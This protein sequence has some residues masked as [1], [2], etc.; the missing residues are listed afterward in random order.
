ERMLDQ[1]DQ[2]AAARIQ[3]AMRI[4][5]AREA[6]ENELPVLLNALQRSQKRFQNDPRAAQQLL[7]VGESHQKK[8]HEAAELAACTVVA[9]LILNLDESINRE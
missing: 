2:S 7:S 9:S 5:L 8:E 1:H 6:S 3:Y 4:V